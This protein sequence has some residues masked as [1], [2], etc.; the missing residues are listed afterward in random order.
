MFK[1]YMLAIDRCNTNYCNY[2]LG[3]RVRR[4]K[5]S[6][7]EGSGMFAWRFAWGGYLLRG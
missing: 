4:E 5:P 6:A 3:L 2:E 1:T 7:E